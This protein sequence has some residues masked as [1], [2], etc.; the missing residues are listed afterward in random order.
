[1]DCDCSPPHKAIQVQLLLHRLLLLL[2]AAAAAA[3]ADIGTYCRTIEE[4]SR[5][6]CVR[7]C[8]ITCTITRGMKLLWCIS[9]GTKL[10]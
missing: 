3:A 1:M 9:N 10:L 6:R 5:C 7:C 8:T 4:S 2:T